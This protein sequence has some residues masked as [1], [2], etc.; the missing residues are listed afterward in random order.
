MMIIS[1]EQIIELHKQLIEETG[2]SHGLRDEG[3]LDSAYN[4]PFQHF[5]HQELSPPFSRN[6]HG[7]LSD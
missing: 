7:L 1:K 6:Q 4:A 3:L 5:D 2:G